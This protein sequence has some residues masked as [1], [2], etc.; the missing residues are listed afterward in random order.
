MHEL[1]ANNEMKPIRGQPFKPCVEP[2]LC[3]TERRCL[4]LHYVLYW[5]VTTP[6]LSCLFGMW[7]LSPPGLLYRI[8]QGNMYDLTMYIDLSAVGDV[9]YLVPT[10]SSLPCMTMYIYAVRFRYKGGL[11]TLAPICWVDWYKVVEIHTNACDS[12]SLRR[13]MVARFWRASQGLNLAQG[14]LVL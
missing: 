6:A 12:Q 9:V 10:Y 8:R 4:L 1:V 11:I 7:L 13:W 5:V 3:W 2:E 14:A